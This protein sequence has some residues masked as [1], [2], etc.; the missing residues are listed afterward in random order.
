MQQA[1]SPAR[2]AQQSTPSHSRSD[3]AIGLAVTSSIIGAIAGGDLA[4]PEEGSCGSSPNRAVLM[5]GVNLI[6]R[7]NLH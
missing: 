4:T 2:R 3:T 1:I 7:T 6:I 5:V